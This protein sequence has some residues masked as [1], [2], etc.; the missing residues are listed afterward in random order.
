M[1]NKTKKMLISALILFC[2]GV[3][4][5]TGGYIAAAIGSVSVYETTERPRADV[6]SETY[7]VGQLTGGA[8]F[9]EIDIR[10]QV[11]NVV[12]TKV[13][14]SAQTTV[15]VS[16]VDMA[17]FDTK[18]VDGVLTLADNDDY[19]SAYYGFSFTSEGFSFNGLRQL[20]NFGSAADSD[21]TLYIN[22]ASDMADLKSIN[23]SCGAGDVILRNFSVKDNVKVSVSCGD[24]RA[25]KVSIGGAMTLNTDLGNVTV[26][27]CTYSRCEAAS[28]KGDITAYIAGQGN[29]NFDSVAGDVSVIVK[30]ALQNYEITM[31]ATVGSVWVGETEIG[32][33]YTHY[34]DSN[35]PS[36]G[37]IIATAVVGSVNI[38][39]ESESTPA[40]V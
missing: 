5:T 36:N 3:L 26:N 6:R 12:I 19:P 27:N 30:N 11:G 13:T 31:S 7:N 1:K 8:S 21:R 16:K 22:L 38:S 37:K 35:T 25:D 24:V 9:S 2:A 14:G 32:S 23:V 17:T 40:P 15:Q 39:Q 29:S 28:T 18:V 10:F 20:L 4:L 33:D 34:P